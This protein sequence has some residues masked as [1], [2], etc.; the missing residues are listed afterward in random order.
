MNNRIILTTITTKL[1]L[2]QQQ[3]Q[4]RRHHHHHH[5]LGSGAHCHSADGGHGGDGYHATWNVSGSSFH[6]RHYGECGITTSR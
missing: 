5:H 2:Q 3:Q 6:L 4:H 1:L